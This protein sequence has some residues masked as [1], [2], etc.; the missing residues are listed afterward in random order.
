LWS[1]RQFKPTKRDVDRTESLAL[2]RRRWVRSRKTPQTKTDEFDFDTDTLI[3]KLME[4]IRA[5]SDKALSAGKV[6]VAT[7]RKPVKKEGIQSKSVV[8]GAKK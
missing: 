6:K 2:K 8:K 7:Q 4:D 3:A 5:D 1:W